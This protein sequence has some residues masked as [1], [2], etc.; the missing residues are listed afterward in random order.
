MKKVISAWA[1]KMKIDG[2]AT[3][4]FMGIFYCVGGPLEDCQDG[5]RTCLFRTRKQARKAAKEEKWAKAKVVRVNVTIEV[6][7]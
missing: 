7:P 6:A 4:N 5:M 2:H 1:V 3:P